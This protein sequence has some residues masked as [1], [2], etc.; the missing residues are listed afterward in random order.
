MRPLIAKLNI[1]LHKTA[2]TGTK[3]KAG[4]QIF[5]IHISRHKVRSRPK[6][7]QL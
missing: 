3:E 2:K 4:I 7:S 6:S 1:G 5:C